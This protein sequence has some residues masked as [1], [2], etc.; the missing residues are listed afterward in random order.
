MD[1]YG[2]SLLIPTFKNLVS[3]IKGIHKNIKLIW[4][5]LA[6]L[7]SFSLSLCPWRTAPKWKFH[8]VYIV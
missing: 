3:I 8:F 1:F 5:S 4:N 2:S 7:P 6:T